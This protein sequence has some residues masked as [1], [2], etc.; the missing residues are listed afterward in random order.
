[1]ADD[2]DKGLAAE[3]HRRGMPYGTDGDHCD[4][5]RREANRQWRSRCPH[6]HTVEIVTFRSARPHI[7]CDDCGATLEDE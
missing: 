7:V 1:M 3:E 5:C 2:I 4:G 6:E